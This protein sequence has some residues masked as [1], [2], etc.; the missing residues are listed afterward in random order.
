MFK[1]F[2]ALMSLLGNKD[3]LQA[4]IVRFQ[5]QLGQITAEGSA[6]AGMVVVTVNG[7]M[8]LLSCRLS[9]EAARLE[10]RELI[11]ELIIAAT[12]Q[13]LNKARELIAAESAKMAG[14]LGLPV[15]MLGGIFPGLG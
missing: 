7:R 1:E 3:K 12:N 15:G 11:E 5:Q 2:G 8:E 13:A 14:N 6:G 9:D 4:E 10:D